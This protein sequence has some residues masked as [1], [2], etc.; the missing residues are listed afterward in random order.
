M[1]A[2]AGKGSDLRDRAT[3]PSLDGCPGEYDFDYRYYEI[4]DDNVLRPTR[5]WCFL[6]EIVAIMAF[7]RLM[8]D[9]R[10]FNGEIARIACYDDDRG[11]SFVSKCKEGYTVGVLYGNQHNFLDFSVGFRVEDVTQMTVRIL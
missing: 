2:P 11:R 9:V 3:F 10:D 4:A 8:V 5:H 1:T 6:G 7:T